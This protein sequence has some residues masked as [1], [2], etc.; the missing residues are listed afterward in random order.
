MS[1]RK[2]AQK[3]FVKNACPSGKRKFH[4]E[5]QAF[6]AMYR[7]GKVLRVYKCAHCGGLHFT[8][9]ITHAQRARTVSRTRLKYVA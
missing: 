9:Q 7:E 2:A 5:H 1:K 4:N 6:G 8:S 3:K